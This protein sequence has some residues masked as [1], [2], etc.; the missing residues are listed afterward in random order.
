MDGIHGMEEMTRPQTDSG[1][2]RARGGHVPEGRNPDPPQ[3]SR[4]GHGTAAEPTEEE[5]E[6]WRQRAHT[7]YRYAGMGYFLFLAVIAL[8]LLR[9]GVLWIGLREMAVTALWL[10]ILL[11]PLAVVGGAA[12]LWLKLGRRSDGRRG[13]DGHAD[14]G[15]T[16]RP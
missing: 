15:G 5:I 12:Y 8:I 7:F 6:R 2:N 16:G 3:A 13:R 4:S 9:Q 10:V 14:G 1:T 11:L